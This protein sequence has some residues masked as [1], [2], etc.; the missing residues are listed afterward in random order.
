MGIW[1]SFTYKRLNIQFYKITFK[2]FYSFLLHTQGKALYR[3]YNKKTKKIKFRDYIKGIKNLKFDGR[4]ILIIVISKLYNISNI[5][6][7]QNINNICYI[8]I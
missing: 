7:K 2:S 6:L 4:F 3:L 1:K 5:I 8:N